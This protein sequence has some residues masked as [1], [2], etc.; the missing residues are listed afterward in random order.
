MAKLTHINGKKLT[1]LNCVESDKYTSTFEAKIGKKY[2][3]I[4]FPN[5]ETSWIYSI[6]Y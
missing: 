1:L 3:Y 4:T 5:T 2:G 6:S